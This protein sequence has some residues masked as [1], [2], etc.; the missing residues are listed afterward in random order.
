LVNDRPVMIVETPDGGADCVVL[1]WASGS[2][3]VDRSYFSRTLPGDFA[4]VD[5]VTPEQMD[6]IVAAHRARILHRLATHLAGTDVSHDQDVLEVLGLRPDTPPFDA[7][8]MEPTVGPGLFVAAPRLLRRDLLDAAL[9]HAPSAPGPA[10]TIAV[11]YRLLATDDGDAACTV[12]AV[13]PSDAPTAEAVL[14]Q[15]ARDAGPTA[16]LTPSGRA[17]AP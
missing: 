15:L 8:D 12:L 7:D 14:V 5:S 2:F 11:S 16:G 10:Q 3:V 13:F 6:A 17:D 9:G 4:D 1:D